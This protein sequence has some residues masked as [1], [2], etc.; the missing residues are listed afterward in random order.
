MN[1]PENVPWYW[2][3]CRKGSQS[4]CSLQLEV[5][6]SP[7]P[8]SAS[9]RISCDFNGYTFHRTRRTRATLQIIVV[10]RLGLQASHRASMPTSRQ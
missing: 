6:F 2:E 5:D 7:L 1:V 3:A 10:A 8:I 9:E 4:D